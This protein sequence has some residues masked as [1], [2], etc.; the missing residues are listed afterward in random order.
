M[1]RRRKWEVHD[2]GFDPRRDPLVF[3]PFVFTRSSTC[4]CW[5]SSSGRINQDQIKH[6]LAIICWIHQP[7]AGPVSP[8]S[9]HH[10]LLDHHPLITIIFRIIILW[11]ESLIPGPFSLSFL[12]SLLYV[13]FCFNHFLTQKLTLFI[14]THKTNFH[15]NRFR[16]FYIIKF[17]LISL[18]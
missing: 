1:V 16:F 11:S 10:H 13:Y 2:F 6:P 17:N 15:Q 4:T 14:K 12:Y 8:S 9:D 18:I 5:G 7:G 3:P